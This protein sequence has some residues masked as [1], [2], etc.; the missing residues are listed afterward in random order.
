MSL[1]HFHIAFIFFC[2]I[3]AFGFATWCFVFRPMQGTTDIM[4][5]AS[6]IGGALLVFYG[7]RFYRK[8]KNVI[9]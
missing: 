3:F 6:A 7:I 4:G 1:K 9:V 8:S 2:A 5:G